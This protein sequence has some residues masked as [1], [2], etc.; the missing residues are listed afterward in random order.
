MAGEEHVPSHE[1]EDNPISSITMRLMPIV[2]LTHQQHHD[3][4]QKGKTLTETS[5]LRFLDYDKPEPHTIT[6]FTHGRSLSESQSPLTNFF[7]QKHLH[8]S[9]FS[10]LASFLC[11]PASASSF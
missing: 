5:E 11:S 4:L 2:S 6:V 7:G 3:K 9:F 8:T 10:F 1:A